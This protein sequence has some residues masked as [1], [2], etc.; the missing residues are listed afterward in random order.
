MTFDESTKT[1]SPQGGPIP[2]M[3]EEMYDLKREDL[4]FGVRDALDDLEEEI[5]KDPEHMTPEEMA[6]AADRMREGEKEYLE[7]QTKN[8]DEEI[9]ERAKFILSI[10]EG[11]DALIDEVNK[12]V[13]RGDNDA[14][15]RKIKKFLEKTHKELE[16]LSLEGED[17]QASL[18]QMEFLIELDLALLGAK[19]QTKSAMLTLL[20]LGLDITPFLGG[21]KM[22]GEG[23]IG[24]TLDGQKL[25]GLRRIVHMGEGLFWEVVDVVA[26]AAAL[27][28]VGAGGAAIEGAA[29]TAKGARA[30]KGATTAARAMEG[31]KV[32]GR[33]AK[34]KK[35]PKVSKTMRRTGAFM[36]KHSIEGSKEVFRAGHFLQ[37]NPAL[38]KVVQ[39]GFEKGFKSRGARQLSATKKAP[40]QAKE[41]VQSH[42]EQVRLLDEINQEREKLTRMLDEMA[43]SL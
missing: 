17:V 41:V 16:D 7:R 20:S 25:H 6:K 3:N 24:Q 18:D 39:G 38:E 32:V 12:D 13:A 21:V 9:A 11:M 36:R 31:A 40:G 27:V 1:D 37:K 35:A 22:M 4:E 15:E 26:V 8:P 33:G 23:A 10:K 43:K 28:S 30:V 34:M 14:A 29:A 42:E 5:L 2:P 19:E